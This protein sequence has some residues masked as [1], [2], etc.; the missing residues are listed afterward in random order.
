[1]KEEQNRAKKKQKA[2]SKLKEHL[3][4]V[5]GMLETP[6]FLPNYFKSHEGATFIRVRLFN[7]NLEQSHQASFSRRTNAN[8]PKNFSIPA[9]LGRR[10][11]EQLRGRLV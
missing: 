1:M 3:D 9:Q 11:S 5:S 10:K 4:L 8:E 2:Q 6:D 7:C